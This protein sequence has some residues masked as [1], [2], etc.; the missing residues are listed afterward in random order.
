M[1]I[2]WVKVKTLAERSDTRR[3]SSTQA[4][5]RTRQANL[6]TPG[7]MLT[8]WESTLAKLMSEE[9]SY[10]RRSFRHPVWRVVT[11]IGLVTVYINILDTRRAKQIRP[12]S[13]RA[14]R[15]TK[16]LYSSVKMPPWTPPCM[17]TPY[18]AHLNRRKFTS[19]A[20]MIGK[21]RQISEKI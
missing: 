6:T 16:N 11:F 5:V 4:T 3:I 1:T 2:I 13:D 10:P 7:W 21:R 9:I 8:G 20:E 18:S 17:V 19:Q 12:F 14:F 15:I